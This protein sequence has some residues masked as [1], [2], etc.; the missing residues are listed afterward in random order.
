M[1]KGGTYIRILETAIFKKPENKKLIKDNFIQH[2]KYNTKITIL[3]QHVYKTQKIQHGK[4]SGKSTTLANRKFRV[5]Q[6]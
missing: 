5:S 6:K 2:K 3:M 1:R 4:Y